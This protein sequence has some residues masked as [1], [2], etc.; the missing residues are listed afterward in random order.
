MS[1]VKKYL[2]E[3]VSVSNLVDDIFTI[4]FRSLA[5]RFRYLPGQFLHLALDE[6][7]P[8]YGW[9]ESRCFSMQSSP[10]SETI[11]ITFSVKGA[12]THRMVGELSVGE[13]VHLK[14][15]YGDIFQRG[16]SKESTV[17][18]AGGTGITPYLSLFND[19]LFAE[20]EKPVL[21]FGI[22]DQKYNL[23]NKELDLAKRINPFLE[24][25]IVCQNTDGILNIDDIADK[26]RKESIYIISGPPAMI[27]AFKITLK[28]RNVPPENI[29]TDDWE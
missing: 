28:G 24:I 4:E 16:H 3:V 6:Y 12:F 10:S 26:S 17:F 9:P 2:S 22:R 11:K 5:G 29:I 27:S 21:Y 7:D 25:I 8:S 20:Y 14:M 19:P 18:I 13:N 1:I 23:Y 15:P